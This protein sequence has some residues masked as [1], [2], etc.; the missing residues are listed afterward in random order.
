MNM[1]VERS[2]EG[3]IGLSSLQAEV[4][5]KMVSLISA[6]RW[7]IGDRLSDVAIAKELRVSRSP[8]R[9]VLNLLVKQGIVSQTPNRGYQLH[10]IPEPN[11]LNDNLLPHRSRKNSTGV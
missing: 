1:D 6:A 11:E 3:E 5:H 2:T 4:A 9:Q 7:N 10:R 8:V